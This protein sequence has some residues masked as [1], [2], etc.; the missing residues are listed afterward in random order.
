MQIIDLL[1]S[2]RVLVDAHVTSKKRLLES[3][4]KLLNDGGD[5]ESERRLFDCLCKREKLGS[6][7]L[8]HGVG[9]P[10][11]RCAHLTRPLAAFV[12]LAEPV[13]FDAADGQPVDLVF[14]LAVPEHYVD[15]H[16]VL[17]AAVVERFGDAAF[18]D[19]VRRAGD[20]TALFAA[21][22]ATPTASAAA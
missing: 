15:Q 13:D 14:C 19:R 10:H 3:L 21:L 5:L 7:G 4:A 2:P 8:G 16:L 11:G 9:L 12:R 17:L 1:T 6:T 22:T 18:R 20:R